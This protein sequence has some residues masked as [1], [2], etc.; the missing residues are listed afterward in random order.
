[1]VKISLTGLKTDKV[2]HQEYLIRWKNYDNS[3]DTWVRKLDISTD[4][5]NQFNGVQIDTASKM[6]EKVPVGH[7]PS[8]VAYAMSKMMSS[9]VKQKI[10]V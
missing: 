8:S 5:I 7:H 4:C 1:M 2:F 6:L 3:H 10:E 9:M